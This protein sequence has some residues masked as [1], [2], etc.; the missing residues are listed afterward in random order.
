[1]LLVWFNLKL[2]QELCSFCVINNNASLI[3]LDDIDGSS[4]NNMSYSNDVLKS[5]RR[6]P[7]MIPT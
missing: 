1:M 2:Y 7:M 4:N 5:N 3:D 6:I